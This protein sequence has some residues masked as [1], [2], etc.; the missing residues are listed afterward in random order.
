MIEPILIKIKMCDDNSFI[1]HISTDKYFGTTKVKGID[2]DINIS[3]PSSVFVWS[4]ISLEDCVQKLPSGISKYFE[5][6]SKS[7]S[8]ML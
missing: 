3:D 2:S 6:K 4:P 7:C 8:A 1:A 5:L